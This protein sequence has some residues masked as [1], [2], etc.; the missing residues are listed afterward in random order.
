MR[1]EE[2]ERGRE[3]IKRERAC[4]VR[5]SS[6]GGG[7]S[8]NGGGGKD[9]LAHVAARIPT[10]RAT[11]D[12][13]E[14]EVWHEPVERG[15]VGAAAGFAGN[16]RGQ[17]DENVSL[18]GSD[19]TAGT[20]PAASAA[21]QQQQQFAPSSS[22]GNAVAAGGREMDH[23]RRRKNSAGQMSLDGSQRSA[24]TSVELDSFESDSSKEDAL[25]GR[26]GELDENTTA[27]RGSSRRQTPSEKSSFRDPA[28]RIRSS[29][30][31]TPPPSSTSH[32]VRRRMSNPVTVPTPISD[33]SRRSPFQG[34]P[35]SA[36]E[37]RAGDGADAD[38]FVP[39]HILSAS[40]RE[41]D[42]GFGGINLEN[43][44]CSVR[45]VHTQPVVVQQNSSVPMHIHFVSL[46]PHSDIPLVSICALCRFR[47][48]GVCHCWLRQ[49]AQGERRHQG[50]QRHSEADGFSLNVL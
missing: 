43:D 19:A 33:A 48:A 13:T 29:S 14:E 10:L 17:N 30:E 20:A 36:A 27:S 38:G 11:E 49:D 15:S 47:L 12:L 40:A 45:C 7:G 8:G 2:R 31:V 26:I 37:M 16:V 46:T 28:A 1:R 41:Y 32:K 35:A 50:P 25:R 44:P 9:V 5:M 39:P 24:G 4:V 34:P 18:D 21:A 23:Q 42:S 3:R 6:H 22:A